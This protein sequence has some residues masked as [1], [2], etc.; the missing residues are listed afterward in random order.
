VS[1]LQFVPT[2]PFTDIPPQAAVYQLQRIEPNGPPREA[3]S[4]SNQAG[5]MDIRPHLYTSTSD[6]AMNH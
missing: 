5:S 3:H 1:I 6:S 4:P 2:I